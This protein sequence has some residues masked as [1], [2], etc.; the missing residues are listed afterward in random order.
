MKSMKWD[1]SMK[2]LEYVS[3]EQALEN[4]NILGRSVLLEAT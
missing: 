1:R 2:K 3:Q 4:T